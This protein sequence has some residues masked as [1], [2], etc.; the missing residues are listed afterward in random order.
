MSDPLPFGPQDPHEP[1]IGEFEKDAQRFTHITDRISTQ[2]LKQ[3]VEPDTEKYQS[4]TRVDIPYGMRFLLFEAFKPLGLDIVYDVAGVEY[5]TEVSTHSIYPIKLNVFCRKDQLHTFQALL[6]A[7]DNN[8]Y[9]K[10]TKKPRMTYTRLLREMTTGA[11]ATDTMLDG[12]ST[13]DRGW[14]NSKF[15]KE[16]DSKGLLSRAALT[17][18]LIAYIENT[19]SVMPQEKLLYDNLKGQGVEPFGYEELNGIAAGEARRILQEHPEIV[20]ATQNPD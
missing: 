10:E 11:V 2:V 13:K 18:I 6:D 14:N 3:C 16:L 9:D 15:G 17:S 4:R 20:F 8:I 19:A 7:I 5:Q 12:T 1:D